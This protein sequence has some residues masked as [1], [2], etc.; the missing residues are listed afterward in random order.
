MGYDYEG[1]LEVLKRMLEEAEGYNRRY[2]QIW[3]ILESPE[4]KM[5]GLPI[6]SS[7]RDM[8]SPA[9]TLVEIRREADGIFKFY[10]YF[11]DEA[12]ETAP[13]EIVARMEKG[14]WMSGPLEPK[15]LVDHF[16]SAIKTPLK[17]I[18]MEKEMKGLE[19]RLLGD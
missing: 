17:V 12:K 11:D 1:N 8:D 14:Y 6:I 18:I 5:K 9:S 2:P 7:S 15:R 4:I 10:G 16:C 13:E 19:R 3:D